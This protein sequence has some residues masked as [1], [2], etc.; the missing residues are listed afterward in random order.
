[1]AGRVAEGMDRC[2]DVLVEGLTFEKVDDVLIR[3]TVAVLVWLL[4]RQCL[5]VCGL[6]LSRQ[7]FLRPEM[8]CHRAQA[9]FIQSREGQYVGL[10]DATLGIKPHDRF[11]GVASAGHH[12]VARLATACCAT[13]RCRALTLLKMK[14]CRLCH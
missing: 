2:V 7:R 4:R 5:Q 14:S 3:D 13:M 11:S 6:H 8:R 9:T 12:A 1:V 10:A